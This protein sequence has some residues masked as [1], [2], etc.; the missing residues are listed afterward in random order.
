[1][2]DAYDLEELS[3]GLN[4]ANMRWGEKLGKSEPFA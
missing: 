4:A 2:Q 3:L 1:M